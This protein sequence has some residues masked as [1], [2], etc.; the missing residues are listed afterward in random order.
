MAVSPAIIYQCTGGLKVCVLCGVFFFFWFFA[1]LSCLIV[2]MATVVTTITGLSTSAIA[3]NGF[4]RGGKRLFT[5]Y[6]WFKRSCC[7]EFTCNTLTVPLLLGGAYYLISRSLGPE[8]GGSI[9]LIFAFANAVAVAMYV[10]GFAETVVELLI[11]SFSG[12]F[13][14]LPFFPAEAEMFVL[15]PAAAAVPLALTLQF[16]HCQ[17]EESPDISRDSCDHVRG[18]DCI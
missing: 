9:G 16:H 6:L 15:P 8:F 17:W 10:V 1:A 12:G 5:F 18:Q 11:V 2:L 4:V 7:F 3:T 13:P 14:A